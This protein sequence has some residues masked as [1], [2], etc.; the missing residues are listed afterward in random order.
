MPSPQLPYKPSKKARQLC[1]VRAKGDARARRSARCP[2]RPTDALQRQRRAAPDDHAADDPARAD[3]RQAANGP[4]TQQPWQQL[5]LGVSVPTAARFELIW[6]QA[7]HDG[8]VLGCKPDLD[9]ELR[10]AVV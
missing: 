7:G 9:Q 10:K 2:D 4:D 8:P 5:A 3:L 1:T 6:P